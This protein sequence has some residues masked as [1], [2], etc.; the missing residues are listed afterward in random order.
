[1][2]GSVGKNAIDLEIRQPGTYFA[3]LSKYG[4]KASSP[5]ATIIA[6]RD[7][8]FVPNIVTLN[9]D[10]FND[11]FQVLGTDLNNFRIHILN[12]YGQLMFEAND[13][14]FKWNPANISTGVYYWRVT[15]T[16]CSGENKEQK[17]WLHLVR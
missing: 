15:Y 12:R 9:N 3:E 2:V 11:Y 7:S 14:G 17:G 8:L 16:N 4:C 13:P 5:P 1:V 10:G 6:K